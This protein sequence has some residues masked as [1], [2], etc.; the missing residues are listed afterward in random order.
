MKSFYEFNRNNP[1]ERLEQY[2][3]YP[4]MALFH[5]AL[6]EEMGEEE[7]HAF[8]RAEKEAQQRF[9]VPVYHETTPQ[10]VNA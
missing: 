3:L 4:E 1:Q 10:W 7:Y 2:K 9:K 8:Y 5:I 6:R